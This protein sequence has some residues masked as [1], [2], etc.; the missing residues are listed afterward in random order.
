MMML[1]LS[2]SPA[3]G[4]KSLAV[5]Y[6]TGIAIIDVCTCKCHESR[7]ANGAQLGRILRKL[8]QLLF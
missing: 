6:A 1:L 2:I 5:S 7:I 3:L 8:V 4:I